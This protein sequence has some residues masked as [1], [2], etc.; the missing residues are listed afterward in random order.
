MAG[1]AQSPNIF[2]STLHWIQTKNFKTMRPPA[3]PPMGVLAAA[4]DNTHSTDQVQGTEQG[5]ALSRDRKH[6]SS[7]INSE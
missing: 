2:T 3:H 7:K 4:G 5:I 6:S 1:A